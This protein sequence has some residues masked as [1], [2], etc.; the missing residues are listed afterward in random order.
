[1]YYFTGDAI[2]W[3]NTKSSGRI[4][5]WIIHK[6]CLVV[7]GSKWITNK[8]IGYYDQFEKFKC[9]L[10]ED[11]DEFYAWTRFRKQKMDIS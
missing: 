9:H 1:M 11:I 3:I 7:V 8:W 6:G 5:P 4:H 10:D 2:F